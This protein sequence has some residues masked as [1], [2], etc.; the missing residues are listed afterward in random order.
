MLKQQ[1]TM[2]RSKDIQEQTRNKIVDISDGE[3]FWTN[4]AF[5][6]IV[7]GKSSLLKAF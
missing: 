4:E 5:N 7:T 6:P 2:A 1:H 3:V